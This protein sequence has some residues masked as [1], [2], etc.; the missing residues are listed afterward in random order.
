LG[1]VVIGSRLTGIPMWVH[2]SSPVRNCLIL[3]Q[4][5]APPVGSMT[6]ASAAAWM[7][8]CSSRAHTWALSPQ[9][10]WMNRA[11]TSSSPEIGATVSGPVPGRNE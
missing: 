10:C 6:L 5:L 3:E 8:A 9:V 11:V 4:M 1:P 7:R 2:S